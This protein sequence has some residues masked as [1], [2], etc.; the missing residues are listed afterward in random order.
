MHLVVKEDRIRF[1]EGQKST[2]QALEAA[3]AITNST[4]AERVHRVVLA[5]RD[6]LKVAV[7]K[8]ALQRKERLARW[9]A[10]RLKT[11]VSVG[12]EKQRKRLKAMRLQERLG[13]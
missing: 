2:P 13:D 4:H 6:K 5:F 9:V 1:W 8:R 12:K 3:L 7:M 11:V 10:Q